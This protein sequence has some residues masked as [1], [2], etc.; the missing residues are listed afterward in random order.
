M[1]AHDSDAVPSLVPI[2]PRR[3]R[4]PFLGAGV[5]VAWPLVA[6]A[7]LPAQL[8]F[9]GLAAGGPRVEHAFVYDEG[10]DTMLRFGGSVGATLFNDTR[11]FDG[12][13]WRTL[14]PATSPSAR[15]RPATAYD[16]ARGEIVLFGG[17]AAGSAM[18]NDTW[19]WNGTNWTQRAP[20][21]SPSARSGAAMAYDP[22]R[23]RVVL[24]G[25]WVPSG[26]DAND[27]WEWDGTNW[28]ADNSTVRPPARGAHRMLYDP[29]RNALV[30]FGGW[31]TPAGGTVG[32]TWARDG[33]GWRQIVGPGPGNRCDPG[34]AFD[35]VRGRIVLFGGLTTF[36]GSTPIVAGDTWE[37][38]N[39]GWSLRAPTAPPSARA[40][41]EMVFDAAR[42]RLVLHGGLDASGAR[43]ETFALTRPNPA[44]ATSYGAACATS[45][46]LP[47]LRAAPYQL[48]WLGDRFRIEV[49][50]SGTTSGQALLWLGASRTTWNG[51]PL[52][53]DLGIVGLTGCQ[54]HAAIDLQVPL[55]LT[56]GE[57]TV[58]A[59]LCGNCPSFV[60]RQI[61]LQALVLDAA[62][63]RPFPGATSAG[64]ALT[65][66]GG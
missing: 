3:P 47:T 40:Y 28:I 38:G 62:A 43:A 64:L 19:T 34:F 39:A 33:S 16:R 21:T 51:V 17:S 66:G 18:L 13:A 27:T 14:S 20:A 15:G 65:L 29:A 1:R 9:T 11:E 36:A 5:T 12:T 8:V 30:M 53:F 44:R 60:N 35:P 2:T 26:L 41:A 59:G 23:Q 42:A 46:G 50:S 56:A 37:F 25:G 7:S 32:D 57:A 52:P 22:D 58:S 24:F 10:R 6:G 55:G 63:P 4:R 61:F 48:P 45:T 31:N 49:A 54:L